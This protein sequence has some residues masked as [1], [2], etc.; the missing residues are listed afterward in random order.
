MLDANTEKETPNTT[1]STNTFL[2][3]AVEVIFTQMSAKRGIA[4]FGERVI[5]AI[6]KEY[7][8]LDKGASPRKP[9]VEP[10]THEDL[11]K[12]QRTLH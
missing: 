3:Q 2:H 5:A 12:E 7:K 4:R 10:I 11:T 9:V 8:Q 1:Y 6:I